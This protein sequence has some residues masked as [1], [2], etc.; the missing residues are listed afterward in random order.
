MRN[1]YIHPE[2]FY[3]INTNTVVDSSKSNIFRKNVGVI[4]VTK[5]FFELEKIR[6]KGLIL[7]KPMSR[8]SQSKEFIND[9]SI[10]EFPYPKDFDYKNVTLESLRSVYRNYLFKNENTIQ[11]TESIEKFY[12][13]NILKCNHQST[14]YLNT[15]KYLERVPLLKFSKDRYMTLSDFLSGQN[16]YYFLEKQEGKYFVDSSSLTETSLAEVKKIRIHE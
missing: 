3:L 10:Y 11:Q 16:L 6:G 5:H 1:L 9:S 13:G 12:V 2:N 15:E 7:P 8:S 14:G 4:Q